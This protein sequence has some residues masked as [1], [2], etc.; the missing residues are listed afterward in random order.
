MKGKYL[1]N[2]FTPHSMENLHTL[3]DNMVHNINEFGELFRKVGIS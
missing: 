2:P 1:T 3:F